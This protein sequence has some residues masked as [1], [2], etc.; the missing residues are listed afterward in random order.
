MH[1]LHLITILL[2]ALMIGN[3]ITVSLFLNP[4]LWKLDD[5]GHTDARAF[6]K[7][8]AATLG[9]I[10]PFWYAACLLLLI[11]EAWL[12]WPTPGR[13]YLLAA[14]ILWTA[15]ILFTV[16]MLVPINNRIASLGPDTPWRAP[17]KRWDT[18]HRIRIALL[19]FAEV[20]FLLGIQ[21]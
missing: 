19:L 5:R 2:T 16:L 4:A 8:L 13:P 17:H 6:V 1:P 21:A 3:E 14:A 12:N 10:M 9:R 20:L 7:E 18:L 11:A 15:T